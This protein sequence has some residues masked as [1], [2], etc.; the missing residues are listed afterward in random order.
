MG[1]FAKGQGTSLTAE[2]LVSSQKQNRSVAPEYERILPSNECLAS[3][4]RHCIF[5]KFVPDQDRANL[6]IKK[7]KIKTLGFGEK[8]NVSTFSLF[9]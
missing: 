3:I 2:A 4:L 8:K 1:L 9:S 6:Q 5:G 7:Q